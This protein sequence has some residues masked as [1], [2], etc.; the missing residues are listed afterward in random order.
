MLNF[1]GGFQ[2]DASNSECS[3]C[4]ELD[5]FFSVRL[6]STRPALHKLDRVNA[7]SV[8]FRQRGRT[9]VY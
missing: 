7:F 5:G 9:E 8:E 3:V 1:I 4:A 6:A 2:K